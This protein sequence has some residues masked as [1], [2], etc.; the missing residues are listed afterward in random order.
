MTEQHHAPDLARTHSADVPDFP[1]TEPLTVGEPATEETDTA[2]GAAGPFAS[3]RDRVAP[4]VATVRGKVA[5]AVSSARER[6]APA[7]ASAKGVVGPAVSTA[8]GKVAPAVAT[9][10]DR[11][12]PAVTPAVQAATERTRAAASTVRDRVVPRA[13]EQSGEHPW[14]ETAAERAVATSG[15]NVQVIGQEIRRHPKVAGSVG[16]ALAAL[17][18]AVWLRLRF[19]RAS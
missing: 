13:R 3:A 10:R 17:V 12:V 2:A 8:K 7:V 14:I 15:K 4:A 5:P 6:V 18:T 1:P 9:A 16:A 19:R 11:V